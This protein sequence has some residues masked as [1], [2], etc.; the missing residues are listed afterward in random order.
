MIEP[1]WIP[2]EVFHRVAWPLGNHGL[3]Y[4][5][6]VSCKVVMGRFVLP[7]STSMS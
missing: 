5:Y 4:H 2:V 6:C 1:D 3:W 7:S